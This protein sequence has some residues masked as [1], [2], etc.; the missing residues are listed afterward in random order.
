MSAKSCGGNDTVVQFS[1]AELSR[2]IMRAHGKTF[3]QWLEMNAANV[4]PPPIR[5]AQKLRSKRKRNVKQ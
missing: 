4:A 2:I 1:D 3:D 5:P